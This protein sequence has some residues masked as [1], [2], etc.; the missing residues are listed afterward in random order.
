MSFVSDYIRVYENAIPATLA[1]DLIDR[2]EG[3][4]NV[5]EGALNEQSGE[6]HP[7]IRSCLELNISKQDDLK[8]HHEA[9]IQLAQIAIQK[10]RQDINHA[11]FPERF[12]MESFRMKKYSP[13]R[14]DHFAH[15]VDVG[16][17]ASARRFLAFF[18]YLNDVEEGGETYFP[19]MNINVRPR[20]NRLLVFPPLW[21]FPHV[22]QKPISGV[23]Y[24]VG[25]YAHYL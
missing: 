8:R 7:E 17:Y 22:G 16:D 19:A 4:P 6:R 2:F 20:A 10:Y 14:E 24:I 9:L 23:K 12:G 18:W 5:I 1:Q 21:M 25:G 11:I 15:H 3:H 13:E